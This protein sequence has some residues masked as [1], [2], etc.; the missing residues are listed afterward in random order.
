HDAG[1][2]RKERTIPQTGQC[3]LTMDPWMGGSAFGFKKNII[4]Q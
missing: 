3:G 1:G 4:R 2:E